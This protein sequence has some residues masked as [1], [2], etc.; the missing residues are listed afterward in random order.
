MLFTVFPKRRGGT[1]AVIS[2]PHILAKYLNIFQKFHYK[3]H[4]KLEN[5]SNLIH[6]SVRPRKWTMLVHFIRSLHCFHVC[7]RL[8]FVNKAPKYISDLLLC[9]GLSRSLRWS[10]RSAYCRQG[11]KLNLEREHSFSMHHISAPTLTYF[12]LRLKTVGYLCV[13]ICHIIPLLLYSIYF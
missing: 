9:S 6:S 4:S 3:C 12:K 1:A 7:Q 8:L 10:G 5:L 11:A 2:I 13:L